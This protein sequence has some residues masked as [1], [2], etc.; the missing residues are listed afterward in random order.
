MPVHEM[1]NEKEMGSDEG[2]YCLSHLCQMI[3]RCQNKEISEKYLISEDEKG[4]NVRIDGRE[5]WNVL[6][7]LLFPS[8]AEFHRRCLLR[9]GNFFEFYVSLLSTQKPQ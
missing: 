3:A 5:K 6:V 2:G 8:P 9:R 7:P 1:E 4:G